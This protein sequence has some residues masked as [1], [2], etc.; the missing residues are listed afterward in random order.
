MGLGC[1]VQ[2]VLNGLDLFSGIGGIALALKPWIRPVVYCEIERH[3]Q[4]VLLSRM[5]DG[6]LPTAPIWDDVR[7]FDGRPWRGRIDIISGGF[8]C[9]DLSVAGDGKGLEGERSGLFFE[10]VRLTR[11]I[12]PR[13][14]F[15]ENVPAL[16]VRGLDRVLL[17]LTALGYDARWTIVSAAEVGAPHRRERIWILA[18]A[19]GYGVRLEQQRM[20]GGR[21]TRVRDQREAEPLNDCAPG[22]MAYAHRFRKLQPAE[23]RD[24]ARLGT[25]Q[26][27][28]GL[29]DA[30]RFGR[31]QDGPWKFGALST[32]LADSDSEGLEVGFKGEAR[33]LQTSLGGGWWATEPDVGRVAHGVPARVDRIR[34]L[35]NAV[36]PIA[37]RTAFTRLLGLEN[38]SGLEG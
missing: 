11:E 15:L 7:T 9:Q 36:V 38:P 1:G 12:R 3:A 35:G 29:A 2:K 28:E 37:A 27:D 22:L 17:E 19:N 31:R 20:P 4:G 34:G 33:E 21:E 16:A 14:L 5:A 18:H 24:R 8:P 6:S 10:I 13:F 26:R 30:P 25:E 23:G 32:A